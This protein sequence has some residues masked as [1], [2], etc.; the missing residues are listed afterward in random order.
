MQTHPIYLRSILIL[1]SYLEIGCSVAVN[2]IPLSH[3]SFPN[4]W[5]SRLLR[6][7]LLTLVNV[8]SS[9]SFTN[10][11]HSFKLSLNL[12]MCHSW[13]QQISFYLVSFK[14][15]NLILWTSILTN[16][17]TANSFVTNFHNKMSCKCINYRAGFSC[18]LLPHHDE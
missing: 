10:S 16:V 8:N 1:Y 4:N 15:L 11:E 7:T 14:N 9:P 12:L 13:I 17:N 5:S 18:C 3:K 6:Q 2:V